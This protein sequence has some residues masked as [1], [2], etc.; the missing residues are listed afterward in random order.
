MLKSAATALAQSPPAR[1][2][3]SIIRKRC[4][5]FTGYEGYERIALSK[6]LAFFNL[7]ERSVITTLRNGMRVRVNTADHVGRVLHVMGDFQPKLSW[8]IRALLDEGDTVLDIGANVGWF[9]ATA[10][11]LVGKAG[12]IHAFEPQP[13]VA[14]MLRETIA[15][16]GLD[17]VE[18][19]EVALSDRDGSFAFHVLDGNAGAG[20]L[21]DKPEG[22]GWQSFDIPTRDAAAMLESL[23]LDPI[24]MIKIDVEGHEATV[25]GACS[26][27]LAKYPADIIMFE[28]FGGAG[29]FFDRD[30]VKILAALGYRFFEFRSAGG[31]CVAEVP[32]SGEGAE[33]SADF[34][35]IHPGPRFADDLRRLGIS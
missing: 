14:A 17:Q 27:Y 8:A 2:L 12:R 35:A 25:L 13:A 21:G 24:R 34:L 29:P 30:V 1:G 5:A 32:A 16:N 33:R 11:P 3:F 23:E 22:E 9:V 26:S 20:R 28:S 18:L 6:P 19:H 15:L 4:R 10:A 31:V 7:A